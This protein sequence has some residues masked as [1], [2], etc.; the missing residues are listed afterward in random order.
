MKMKS[1]L[2]S[3]ALAIAEGVA[4]PEDEERAKTDP[5]LRSMVRR[6][7]ELF[8][9]LDGVCRVEHGP[10]LPPALQ[11]WARAWTRENAAQPPTVMSRL[12]GVLAMGA[13]PLAEAR[14]T[15]IGPQAVLFGDDTYQLDIRLEDHE[16]G[17]VE[18]RGQA[19]ALEDDLDDGTSWSVRVVGG[20][21]TV[22][23]TATDEHGLF[24]LRVEDEV[25]GASLVADRGPI[26]LV[27]PRLGPRRP[28]GSPSDIETDPEP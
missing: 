5:E 25:A 23:H 2:E 9:V 20:E 14:G 8:G 24:L 15:A 6:F 18:I 16:D 12:L 22:Y 19:V 4:T 26:R 11:H 1:T 28:L 17:G 13:T 27:V 7:E 3:L 10:V 21:G